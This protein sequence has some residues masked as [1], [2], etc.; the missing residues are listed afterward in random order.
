MSISNKNPNKSF[1]DLEKNV[2]FYKDTERP[3]T[4]IYTNH[5][6]EG[7]YACKNC[8]APLYHSSHK[9]DS[10]CG[11]PAFDD[12]IKGAIKKIPDAD[13]R[14]TEI[15]C[16]NCDAHLG[17]IFT[18]EG[19][20]AKNLRH[21]VNSVS[22]HFV[23]E[24]DPSLEVAIV[25]AGCFW[26]VEYWFK[27]L[28][29]VLGVRVGYTGG[30]TNNPTYREI[31]RGDTGH[32]EAL[33][34]VF[35]PKIVSYEEVIKYFFEIHD[36]SQTDGQG[37]DVGS[38]YLSAIF[39]RDYNQAQIAHGVINLLESKVKKVA[40]KILPESHFYN[41]EDYHQDYYTKTGK[42][43]YCHFYHKIF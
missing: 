13:G 20:T 15:A 12:E 7:I 11:W 42:V 5:F 38:Q 2:L 21:C 19:A 9:F 22:M 34:V 10:S 35:D 39:T 26:G 14:R 33:K 17:H 6:E 4:G 16:A 29:G 31:C 32:L 3:F 28:K 27:K 41:A 40:T 1:T 25:G 23:S 24:N 30:K 18:G 8:D 36:F 37:N 43:P